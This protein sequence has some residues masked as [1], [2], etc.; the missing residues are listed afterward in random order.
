MLHAYFVLA[1]FVSDVFRESVQVKNATF[2]MFF[3]PI[4]LFFAVWGNFFVVGA[5]RFAFY[6]RRYSHII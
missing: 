3:Y 1:V 6:R 4:S 2:V 5:E